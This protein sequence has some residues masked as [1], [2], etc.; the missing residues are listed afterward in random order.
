[1][2]NLKC[3]LWF[4]W[5]PY[6]LYGLA[7]SWF[8]GIVALGVTDAGTIIIVVRKLADAGGRYAAMTTGHVIRIVEG[9]ASARLMY[10][11]VWHVKQCKRLGP[12]AP[13]VLLLSALFCFW[14]GAS[15]YYDNPFEAQAYRREREKFGR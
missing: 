11:E 10:H 5:M 4:F 8:G 15:P 6:A 7:A 1:M 13:V 2:K 9:Q 14:M 12:F 3:V